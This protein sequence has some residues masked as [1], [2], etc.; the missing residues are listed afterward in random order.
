MIVK[1]N[2]L[3]ILSLISVLVL[4]QCKTKEQQLSGKTTFNFAKTS[5]YDWVGGQSGVSGMLVHLEPSIS[6]FV[7][8][9]SLYFHKRVAKIDVKQSNK[10][11]IWVANYTNEVAPDRKMCIATEDEYGNK[12]PVMQK[13][14]FDLKE[15]EA[16]LSYFVKDKKY[17]YKISALTKEKTVYYP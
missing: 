2:S 8:P 15:D 7:K 13:F 14:L 9:D 3:L 17:Y 4:A 16:M 12:P 10:G 1:K 6:G 5:Y 11:K